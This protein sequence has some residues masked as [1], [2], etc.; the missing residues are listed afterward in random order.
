MHYEVIPQGLIAATRRRT[1]S[2]NGYKLW[3]AHEEDLL[4]KGRR[5]KRSY[6]EI[7]IEYFN[8]QRSAVACSN[9]VSDIKKRKTFKKVTAHPSGKHSSP[10]GEFDS[11]AFTSQKGTPPRVGDSNV[12]RDRPAGLSEVGGVGKGGNLKA[13]GIAGGK[14]AKEV[15][16]LVLSD[17]SDSELEVRPAVPKNGPK[18]LPYGAS[19]QESRTPRFVGEVSQD[20]KPNLKLVSETERS[21]AFTD[22]PSSGVD[23]L[24]ALQSQADVIKGRIYDL[25]VEINK[26]AARHDKSI[27]EPTAKAKQEV[28]EILAKITEIEEQR[29]VLKSE[30]EPIYS[31]IE[32]LRKKIRHQVAQNSFAP[33]LTNPTSSS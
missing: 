23:T 28:R 18:P 8:G 32:T 10:N 3:T 2:S 12:T 16:V 33:T 20:E 7:S 5:A 1:K 22:T 9:H 11:D 29:E 30:N 14:A 27:H 17:D 21:L 26:L 24:A 31:K 13:A 6:P 25:T 4:R 19:A 15:E